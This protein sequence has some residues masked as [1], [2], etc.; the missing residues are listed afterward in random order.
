VSTLLQIS[1]PHFGT[2]QVPVVAALLQLARTLSPELVV[3]SGDITQ[4]ARASQWAAAAAFAKQLPTA[5]LV[6]IPGNHDIPMFNVMARAFAPY[7]GFRGAFG[8]D[9]EPEFADDDLRVICVNTTRP[10]RRKDGEVSPEQIERVAALLR[11]AR[12]EQLR[13]VVVHQPVHVIRKQDIANLLHGHIAAVRAWSRAGA[14]IVMGGHI[15]LPYV[16]PLNDHVTDLHRR[17]WAVQA[18]TATS[19]R[20]RHGSPNS[21]NVVRYAAG[22]ANCIVEQWDFAASANEFRC[23]ERCEL[24]LDRQ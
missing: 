6:A 15:H 21:V 22:D 13:I 24:E 10:Q 16:R 3:F 18:G 19:S 8:D 12:R 2:E 11:Q 1:D 20:V 4:R 5:R 9:L 7:A 23:A 14:D 17:I